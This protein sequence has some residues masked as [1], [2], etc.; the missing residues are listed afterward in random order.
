MVKISGD[1]S[2]NYPGLQHIKIKL[3]ERSVQ[4]LLHLAEHDVFRRAVKKLEIVVQELDLLPVSEK[5]FKKMKK[6]GID[7]ASE[8]RPSQ[9]EPSHEQLSHHSPQANVSAQEHLLRGRLPQEQ[10]PATRLLNDIREE[11]RA[12]LEFQNSGRSIQ[13]SLSSDLEGPVMSSDSFLWTEE[14]D[15]EDVRDP[16]FKCEYKRKISSDRRLE[17]TR[18]D[19]HGAYQAQTC[20]L[21]RLMVDDFHKLVSACQ[22]FDRLGSLH[23][24]SASCVEFVLSDDLTLDE[25]SWNDRMAL[26][27]TFSKALELAKCPVQSITIWT[28]PPPSTLRKRAISWFGGLSLL[29]TITSLEIRDTSDG[30]LGQPWAQSNL[31]VREEAWAAVF[32]RTNNLRYLNVKGSLKPEQPLDVAI[33]ALSSKKLKGISLTSMRF[34]SQVLLNTI[35]QHSKTLNRLSLRDSVLSDPAGWK[36]VVQQIQAAHITRWK[37]ILHK[38]WMTNQFLQV[39]RTQRNRFKGDDFGFRGPG[40]DP[41]YDISSESSRTDSD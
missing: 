30:A 26:Y 40:G 8:S 5:Y 3:T 12:E 14:G 41:A 32:E 15:W 11:S 23:I 7:G 24:S 16:R 22:R 19:I 33:S 17:W 18:E 25:R 6:M 13:R 10:H 28:S 38:E 34:S 1:S 20:L 21:R 35:K 39:W 29:D 2:Q 36:E 27:N 9:E 37:V 31:Q 4:R